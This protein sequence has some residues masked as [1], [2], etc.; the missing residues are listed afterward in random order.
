MDKFILDMS[1][2]EIL[3]EI[4]EIL[5]KKAV[6]PTEKIGWI[7]DN[8]SDYFRENKVHNKDLYNLYRKGA[9]VEE[10]I[11]TL[12]LTSLRNRPKDLFS[13]IRKQKAGNKVLEYGCG[14]STHGVACAQLGCEVH[15]VDI[16]P[17]MLAIA[18]QRYSNRGLPVTIHKIEKDFP[19]LPEKYFDTIICTDVVEHVPNPIKLLKIFITSLKVGGHIHLHVSP[20]INLKKGHLPQAILAW[21]GKGIG[22]MKRRFKKLS[23]H[24]YKLIK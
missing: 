21:K 18:K 6:K 3:K 10:Y 11:K 19:V 12:S 5:G 8:P 16:S 14:T 17:R 9:C 24:N 1:D 22:I 7:T 2:K 23:N 15:V 13:L 20:M 4:S